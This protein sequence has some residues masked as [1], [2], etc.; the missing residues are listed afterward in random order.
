[1]LALIS[2]SQPAALSIALMSSKTRKEVTGSTCQ[3]PRLSGTHSLNN[4][5]LDR[6]HR[7]LGKSALRFGLGGVLTQ[8]GFDR[9][10]DGREF[11]VALHI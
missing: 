9:L 7:G 10:H 6:V 4:P 1:M 11:V 8:D 3:P 5:A 2:T